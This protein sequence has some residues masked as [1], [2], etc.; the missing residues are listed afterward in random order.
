VIEPDGKKRRTVTVKRERIS[1]PTVESKLETVGG[2]KVGVVELLT[3]S[4]GAHGELRAAID[5]LRAQGARG[6]ILDL[7]G[8]GGGLLQEAVLVSSIFIEDGVVVSTDGRNRGRQTFTAEGEALDPKLPVVV[9]VDGGSASASEIV[10]G[11]LRDRGRATL[12][13]EKT[14]GKGVFQEVV[15]LS[16]G[17]A[18]DLTVGR[19]FLPSG[20]NIG[21]KGIVPKTKARDD[22]RT[23]RDEALPVALRALASGVR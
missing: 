5:R 11:A 1:V 6:L 12:V 16:N 13:G 4:S 8:N 17:G 10:A 15:P 21:T 3:F 14:F 23:P 18:L 9:L 19:Y 22:P 7:R 2:K 20:E